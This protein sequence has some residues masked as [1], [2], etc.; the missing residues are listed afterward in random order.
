MGVN[1]AA[2]FVRLKIRRLFIDESDEAQRLL[3]RP[4][5]KAT[6]EHEQSGDAARIIVRAGG[7]ENGIV[8]SADENNLR[9][10]AAKLRFDVIECATAQFVAVP[11]RLQTGRA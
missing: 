7:T 1:P 3:R 4:G 10:R 2:H 11:P 5:G 6:R 8:M 9:S